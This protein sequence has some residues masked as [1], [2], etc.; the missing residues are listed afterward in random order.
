MA[1]TPHNS[2]MHQPVSEALLVAV[3]EQGERRIG[4][5]RVCRV[6][7]VVD[8]GEGIRHRVVDEGEGE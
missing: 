2:L 5:G 4:A 6:D 1:Q 7:R 3:A 8:E